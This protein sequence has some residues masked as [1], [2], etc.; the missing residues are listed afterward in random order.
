MDPFAGNAHVTWALYCIGI[1]CVV[2]VLLL[3]DL[4]ADHRDELEEALDARRSGEND[5]TRMCFSLGATN[6]HPRSPSTE[7][8]A[9]A[10]CACRQLT[11]RSPSDPAQI[12]LGSLSTSTPSQSK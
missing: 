11:E 1:G 9:V 8:P 12:F 7:P 10:V 4:A 2:A 3:A 5:Y 6:D